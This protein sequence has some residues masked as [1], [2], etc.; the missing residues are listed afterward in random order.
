[1]ARSRVGRLPLVLAAG[2]LALAGRARGQSATPSPPPALVVAPGTYASAVGTATTLASLTISAGGAYSV[3]DANVTVVGGVNAMGGLYVNNGAIVTVVGDVNVTG[4]LS[5]SGTSRLVVGGQLLVGGNMYAD[6]ANCSVVVAGQALLYGTASLRVNS[7]LAAAS[8]ILNGTLAVGNGAVVRTSANFTAV[9]A[10]TYL[11]PVA[12]I[13]GPATFDIG[14]TLALD[15]GSLALNGATTVR[16]GAVLVAGGSSLQFGSGNNAAVYPDWQNRLLV[17]GDVVVTYG[18]LTLPTATEVAIGGS[19]SVCADCNASDA[20]CGYCYLSLGLLFPSDGARVA[21]NVT[22]GRRSDLSLSWA[23]QCTLSVGSDVLASYTAQL[24]IGGAFTAAGT[25][26][27]NSETN[28]GLLLSASTGIVLGSPPGTSAGVVTSTWTLAGTVQLAAPE[29]TV[30]EGVTTSCSARD[31]PVSTDDALL[32]RLSSWRNG[33]THPA[34]PLNRCAA[35][36][37]LT[38]NATGGGVTING[39]LSVDS[40]LMG[41]NVATSIVCLRGSSQE[42]TSTYTGGSIL[43]LA[44]E[45]RASTGRL[46]ARGAGG[47]R[48]AVHCSASPFAAANVT[49][50][51]LAVDASAM[52]ACFRD[53]SY[54]NN[55]YQFI[56]NCRAGPPGQ[57]YAACG[58]SNPRLWIQGLPEGY[59]YLYYLPYLPAPQPGAMRLPV[60]TSMRLEEVRFTGRQASFAVDSDVPYSRTVSVLQVDRTVGGTLTVPLDVNYDGDSRY[61]PVNYYGPIYSLQQLQNRP[62]EAPLLLLQWPRTPL[63]TAD[64]FATAAGFYLVGQ[65][66]RAVPASCEARCALACCE[67]PGCVGYTYSLQPLHVDA[68]AGGWGGMAVVDPGAARNCLLF[69][70][71]TGLAPSLHARTGVLKAT[72]PGSGVP[73]APAS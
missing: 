22:L 50:W 29:I 43:V 60:D 63:L 21:G 66:A 58:S 9:A 55:G 35:G 67:Q 59:S 1:M 61:D 3:A 30:H 57:I 11:P 2:A 32:L 26:Y 24:R 41:D 70:N 38:L 18:G 5:I 72:V 71:V 68:L 12:L 64:T 17:A 37:A 25:A 62:S 10:T 46:S 7:S 44:R 27:I 40:V 34:R 19:L 23:P 49:D 31:S 16:A 8:V 51:P 13:A 48:I 14:G 6:G 36:C 20:A 47:G 33:V 52:G 39:T 45:L 15:G 73:G 28:A 4:S 65:R 69:S 54:Y 42:T 53:Y 56:Y